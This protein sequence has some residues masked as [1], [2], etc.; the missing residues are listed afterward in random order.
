MTDSASIEFLEAEAWKQRVEALPARLKHR[1]GTRVRRFGRAVALATP[2]ADV[3]TVNRTIGIGLDHPLDDALLSEV[4]AFFRDAGVRRWLID[5]G[6]DAMIVGGPETL[7]RQGGV[8]KTPTVK[9]VGEPG[10]VA[11][12]STGGLSVREVDRDFAKTFRSIVGEAFGLPEFVKPDLDSA[13]GSRGWHYYMAF[14]GERPIAG[15][16]MFVQNGGAW[17]GVAGTAADARN[18]G[19]Q[20]ALL[21][22]RLT[23]AKSL[24]CSWVTAETSP[25]SLEHSNPS[26]RN[27][28]RAGLRV[29]YLRDKYVF[30]NKLL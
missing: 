4:N 18:R 17:F 19:A 29:A 12:A 9:L 23:D 26:Y 11:A 1:L 7:A 22:R 6:P 14:D 20:T 10:N 21:A 8:L 16:A 5:C 28:L 3:A 24:G 15:A 27:M 2:G 25:D 30:E 13:I